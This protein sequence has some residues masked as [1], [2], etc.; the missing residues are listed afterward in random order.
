M[1]TRNRIFCHMITITGF[2]FRS[3]QFNE[4][5]F[6]ILLIEVVTEAIHATNALNIHPTYKEYEKIH[7]EK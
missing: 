4:R 3:V 5:A 1:M 7:G 6:C 2:T